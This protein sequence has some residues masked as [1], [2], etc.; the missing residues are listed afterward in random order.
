M[1]YEGY[2]KT[3]TQKAVAGHDWPGN[4]RLS[5][6]KREAVLQMCGAQGAGDKIEH[7][8]VPDMHGAAR[9]KADAAE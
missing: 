6:Y 7:I 4:T 1:K 5:C 9:S 3:R 8:R 2:A